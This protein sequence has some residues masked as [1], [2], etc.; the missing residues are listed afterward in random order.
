MNLKKAIPTVDADHQKGKSVA[1][2]GKAF[3]SVAPK[4]GEATSG[5]T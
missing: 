2:V 1:L 5:T 3:V 4:R